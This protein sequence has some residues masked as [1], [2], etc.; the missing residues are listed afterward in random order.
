MFV[1]HLEIVGDIKLAE[2]RRIKLVN[3][4]E[5]FAPFENDPLLSEEFDGRIAQHQIFV[6]VGEFCHFVLVQL[7]NESF[8]FVVFEEVLPPRLEFHFLVFGNI[9]LY[10]LW[11][12]LN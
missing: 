2:G 12:C 4:I 10:D 1:R 8:E 9:L 3:Q 5:Q 6:A 11:E 7:V